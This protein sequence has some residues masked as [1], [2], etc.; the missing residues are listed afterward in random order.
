[1]NKSI[2]I[3]Q[4]S[5]ARSKPRSYRL[6]ASSDRTDGKTCPFTTHFPGFRQRLVQKPLIFTRVRSYNFLRVKF[7]LDKKA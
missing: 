6:M 3:F 7:K 1:M 2:T 4:P 5:T